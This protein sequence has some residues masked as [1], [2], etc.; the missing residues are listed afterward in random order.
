MAI[1]KEFIGDLREAMQIVDNVMLSIEAEE[2]DDLSEE[3]QS[4]YEA[5]EESLENIREAVYLLKET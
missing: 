4:A 1:D 2:S 3:V 5:L